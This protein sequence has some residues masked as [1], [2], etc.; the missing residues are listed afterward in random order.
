MSLIHSFLTE[1]QRIGIQ[2][3]LGVVKPILFFI[4]KLSFIP[5]IAA[6]LLG[7]YLRKKEIEKDSSY[8]STITFI[9]TKKINSPIS[10]AISSQLNLIRGGGQEDSEGIIDAIVKSDRMIL[11]VLFSRYSKSDSAFL[12]NKFAEVYYPDNLI[13][14][15]SRVDLDSMSVSEKQLYKSVFGLLS[16]EKAG[17]F[18]FESSGIVQKMTVN[19]KDELLTYS[20]A[21]NIYNSLVD[22]YDSN[23]TESIDN[24]LDLL[25]RKRDS[26][27]GVLKSMN[28]KLAKHNDK[29]GL[30]RTPSKNLEQVNLVRE[31]YITEAQYNQLHAQVEAFEI[32]NAD[33]NESYFQ[34]LNYPILPLAK[35]KKEVLKQ[36]VIGGVIGFVIGFVLIILLF[37]VIE[38][39]RLLRAL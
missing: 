18:Q 22:F 8:I 26:V 10:S 1:E 28:R 30:Y 25:I 20:L 2:K 33:G 3:G 29:S 16:S 14:F 36:T 11:D 19:T 34:K 37:V 31:I 23:K 13:R 15:T 24:S 7:Y 27:K 39:V 21:N 38:I 5:I 4:L 6:I 9:E 35:S 17:L 12:I 32:S